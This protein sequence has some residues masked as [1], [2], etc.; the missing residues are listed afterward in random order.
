MKEIRLILAALGAT[1]AAASA[2]IHKVAFDWAVTDL[3]THAPVDTCV[4]ASPHRVIVATNQKL[5]L[6]TRGGSRRQRSRCWTRLLGNHR[7]TSSFSTLE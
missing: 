2:Q 4:A 5:A 3:T 7:R 1:A 6:F